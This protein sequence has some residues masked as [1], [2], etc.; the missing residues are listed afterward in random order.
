MHIQLAALAKQEVM[1]VARV[2]HT[3]MQGGLAHQGPMT[4]ELKARLAREK[5]SVHTCVHIYV[6]LN[7]IVFGAHLYL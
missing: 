4:K 7:H 1:G 2:V 5:V 6:I 3:R